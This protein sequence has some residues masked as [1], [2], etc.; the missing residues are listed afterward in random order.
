MSL[1]KI[2]ILIP[3]YNY[4]EFIM[5]AVNS[6]VNQTYPEIEILVVDDKSTDDSVQ[7]VLDHIKVKNTTDGHVPGNQFKLFTGTLNGR[8]IRVVS[9][10]KN[11]GR[12]ATRN[13]GINILE[14][15]HKDQLKAVCTLDSDDYYHPDKVQESVNLLK[16]N[17]IG[18]GIVYSDYTSIHTKDNLSIREYKPAFSNIGLLH[19]CI[20]NSNSLYNFI[21][22]KK[23][24]W[25]NP[26]SPHRREFWPE[27]IST[28]EDYCLYLLLMRNSLI[29]HIPK[30]LVT[31][32]SHPKNSTFT[33]S[34][35]EWSRNRQQIQNILKIRNGQP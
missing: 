17:P 3:N 32:R 12:A 15:L 20:V 34:Q 11:S 10:E 4:A 9:K 6:A 26:T 19:D 1:I 23:N 30:D 29:F 7:K 35:A 13:D 31:V 8:T 2:P 28:A 25:I 22:L 18:I 14:G 16:V 5:D 21:A 24:M 33:V 27:S